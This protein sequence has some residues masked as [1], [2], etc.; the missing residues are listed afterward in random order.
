MRK[1]EVKYKGMKSDNCPLSK[2]RLKSLG[3]KN[4]NYHFLNFGVYI[5]TKHEKRFLTQSPMPL[6][7]EGEVCAANP[8]LRLGGKEGGGERG[9]ASIFALVADTR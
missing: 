2:N 1:N 4:G 8:G 3:V 9:G 6:A 7:R 5:A